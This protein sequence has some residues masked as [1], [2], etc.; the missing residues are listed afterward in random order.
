MAAASFEE[1]RQ[2]IWPRWARRPRWARFL[3]QV[4]AQQDAA[5]DA[6]AQAVLVRLVSRC[7]DD[8]LDL[9]GRTLGCERSPRE[10]AAAYRRYLAQAWQVHRDA[11]SR[12]GLQRELERLWTAPQI[13]TWRDLA[14]AGDPG[15]FGGDESC[16]FVRV[17]PGNLGGPWKWDEPGAKWDDAGRVWDLGLLGPQQRE[18]VRLTAR[19]IQR[20][21]PG[22]MTCRFIEFVWTVDGMGAPL[23]WARVPVRERWEFNEVGVAIHSY[24]NQGY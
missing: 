2:E 23:T 16:F 19:W 8:A 6:L 1:L 9:L 21:R 11:G 12:A 24:Y 10:D 15:A 18:I 17:P 22:G 20:W 7:P 13:W 4:A 3:A 5:V 14:D